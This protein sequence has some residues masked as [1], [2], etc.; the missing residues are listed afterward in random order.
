MSERLKAIRYQLEQAIRDLD[1]VIKS[2]GEKCNCG[3]ETYHEDK[4]PKSK[5]REEE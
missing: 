2:E 4:C 5:Q 3:Q 1:E